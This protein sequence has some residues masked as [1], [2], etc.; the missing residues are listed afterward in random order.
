MG[1]EPDFERLSIPGEAFE[2]VLMIDSSRS[3]SISHF[4]DAEAFRNTILFQEVLPPPSLCSVVYSADQQWGDG[5]GS[6]GSHSFTS[7]QNLC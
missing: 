2:P 4:C 6:V 5:V 7:Q 3:G 1:L